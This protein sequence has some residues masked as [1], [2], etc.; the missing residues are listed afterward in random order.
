MSGLL[1]DFFD[2]IYYP[3]LEKTQAKPCAIF[4][5]A[6]SDGTGTKRALETILT[7]LRWKVVQEPLICKGEWDDDFL[8]QCEELGLYVAASLDAG[9]L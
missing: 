4:I 6:G 7:G 8:S 9:I 5:R 3:C 1:K 2:R